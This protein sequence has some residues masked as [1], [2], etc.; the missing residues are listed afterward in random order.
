MKIIV[1]HSNMDLDCLGS[2]ALARVLF[3]GHRA[4]RS[5][6]IHPVARTLYNLYADHLDLAMPDELPA[7]AVEEVV[8]VDTRS[9]GRLR[10]YERLFASGP[11]VEV[12]DHHP[13]DS[14]DIDGALLCGAPAGSNTTL[15]AQEAMRRGLRLGPEDAT[16]A[17]TGVFAD[18][19]GFLHENVTPSDFSAAAWLQQ[20]GGSLTLVKSFLRTLKEESQLT[21]F[22]ELLHHL[23]Y[24]TVHGHLV[25]ML[26]QEMDRQVAG[27][28]AV[29]EKVLEVES[30]DAL[31]AVFSF[32]RDNEV[33]LIG[34]GQ[35]PGLDVSRI[36][37][38]FGGG[39]HAQASSALLKG[40]H[41][42]D[43]F[44]ALQACLKTML[45]D[46]LSATSI[47]DTHVPTIHADSPLQEASRLLEISDRTGMPV[48]D[49]EG[50]L[51]GYLGLR[52]IA[53]ARRG[54]QLSGPVGSH[55]VRRVVSGTPSS[56][57]REIENLFFSHTIYDL[58][59]VEDGRLVGIVR[60]DAYLRARAG[61]PVEV[62]G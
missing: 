14:S 11:R 47:M 19:G 51:C 25:L 9:R 40:A 48:T 37:R 58:P 20:Q 33:L 30:P 7:E 38:A 44:H 39:G 16:I 27:L 5:R 18:T 54:G 2:L 45:A 62:H 3:P 49:A 35:E 34:R 1:G 26:Y 23:S 24:Q 22:H 36:L 50:K 31:F 60:R 46:A 56:S 29:V 52:D 53:K 4:V 41:G 8:V 28:A 59:I 57:L 17:L 32:L 13:D 61:Q 55:M 43:T 6:L 15:L 21:I 10:E 42:R 12:W